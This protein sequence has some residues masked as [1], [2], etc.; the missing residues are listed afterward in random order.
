MKKF[1]I[2]FI[3]ILLIFAAGGFY[4][5]NSRGSSETSTKYKEFSFIYEDKDIDKKDFAKIDGQYYLSLDFIKEY[6]DDT[7]SYDESE[8]AVIFVN[9]KGTKRIVLGANEAFLNDQRVG[10]RSAVIEKDGKVLIPSEIFIYD[11]PVSLRYIE[12]KKVLVMDRKDIEYAVGIPTGDGL[13]MREEDSIKSPIVSILKRDNKVYVYGEKGDF[14]KV[15]EIDGYSGY[16]KKSLLDVEF[17]KNKFKLEIGIDNGEAV[18]PLNLTWDYT[19]GPQSQES[20]DAITSIKG[21]NV[22]CPTWFSVANSNLDIIDRGNQEYVNKYKAL[23]IEVWAYLDN[24]FNADLTHEVLSKSSSRYILA[25]KTLRLAKRYGLSGVNV[26]FENTKIEDR[27]NI[28]QFVRELSGMFHSEGLKVSVDVTPQ[29]S[30]DVTKEPY[31]R[32]ELARFC[33]YVIL[34]AYD[35]HWA[36]SKKAGSVAEYKWVEG[37]LNVLFRQI[38]QEK[39]V[40]GV[41]LYSRLWSENDSNVKSSSLSMNQVKNI[42]ESKGSS[43]SW[44]DVSKQDYTEYSENDKLYKIWI[45]DAKSIEW[46][47]S[48]I[49]KYNLAGIASWRKGFETSDIWDTIDSVLSNIKY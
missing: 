35:Q 44:D 21:L 28:T 31:N 33:D 39:L 26:D 38:P 36:S 7:I 18:K 19:Y 8:K 16:I 14:Y 2:G 27:E 29:I 32:K 48:L 17:P 23:G 43:I 40:L 30:S 47:T 6:I 1:F 3:F 49:N 15:R 42:I 22:I 5:L 37:N 46:K 25:T 4:F 13:N 9:T 20:I 11:Y 10:L 24:S 34:M 12:D 45:E 41:P